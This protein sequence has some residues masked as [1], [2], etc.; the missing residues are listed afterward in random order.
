MKPPPSLAVTLLLLFWIG[1]LPGPCPFGGCPEAHGAAAGGAPPPNVF[2]ISTALAGGLMALTDDPGGLF[3]SEDGGRRWRR[4]EGLPEATLYAIADDGRGG[5]FLATAQGIFRS[6]DAG[7]RFRRSSALNAALLA[8]SPDSDDALIKIW[9]KG[10]F[11]VRHGDLDSASAEDLAP[12]SGLPDAPVQ[13]LVFGR[14]GMAFAGLFGRGVFESRD[15]GRT[16]Q[17]MNLG[18]DNHDVLALAVSS[19]GTLF[20]GTYGGGLFRWSTAAAAWRPTGSA[21]VRG[22]V[23]CLGQGT[24]GSI[25]AGT[26][27]GAV[28]VSRD[29]GKTWTPLPPIRDG[30]NIHALAADGDGNVWAGAWEAGLVLLPGGGSLWTLRPFADLSTVLQLS[31]NPRDGAWY[32]GVK[33]LGLLRSPD[34]GATWTPVRLPFPYGDNMALMVHDGRLYVGHPNNGP[35]V[36]NDGGT[37]WTKATRGLPDDGVHS[38]RCDGSGNAFSVSADG[39][40]LYRLTAGGIWR[41]VLVDDEYGADY[42][43][44]DL[45]FL[46]GGEAAAYGYNDMLIS[47][48]GLRL[49][50]RHRFG[51][52]F[53]SLW[54]DARGKL[55]TR[56]MLTTFALTEDGRDWEARKDSAGAHYT[57]FVALPPDR[58]VAVA[59]D[60]GL[61]VLQREGPALLPMGAHL[62]DKR[63]HTVAVDR[64]RTILAGTDR[65]LWISPDSGRSWEEIDLQP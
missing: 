62:Q 54:I 65:G 55:W 24:G 17:D 31:V 6:A 53:N 59:M 8:F 49:W 46:P 5:L 25:L 22:I 43:A 2:Q 23:Q 30:A 27:E 47:S 45:V 51:Q 7:G 10:V 1:P 48:G 58:V 63:V 29:D 19:E 33:G 14:H 41:R 13:S 35:L 11:R 42:S 18:L 15:G 64:N 21:S 32:A 57:A 3:V 36:S 56:R 38:L 16:F 44:W 20:A 37:G 4:A 28:A 26:R 9:G 52:A 12:V 61:A 60:G 50:R 40:G 34:R 39:K